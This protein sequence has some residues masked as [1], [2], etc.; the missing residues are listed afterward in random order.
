MKVLF[1]A[2]SNN[3]FVA[4][5]G[6]SQRSNLLLNALTKIADVDVIS[7][8]SSNEQSKDYTIIHQEEWKNP[9]REGRL[10]KFRR[11]L[12]PWNI[13]SVFN[14]D[15]HKKY[16][17]E[18]AL[19]KKNYDYIVIRYIPAA[20]ECGLWKYANK[21]VVDIDDNPVERAKADADAAKSIRNRIY[22]RLLSRAMNIVVNKVI[23]QAKVTFVSNPEDAIGNSAILLPNVPYYTPKYSLD[24][25]KE[26]KGRILF[27]GDLGYWVNQEGLSRFLQN[28]Y[29]KVKN[30]IPYVELHIVGRIWDDAIKAEWE[31]Y[32]GVTVTGFVPDILAEYQEAQV[33]IIPI[34]HGAG[35]CIKVLETMQMKKVCVTTPTGFRGYNMLFESGI[36]SIVA[37]SDDDFASHLIE[38]INNPKL[39]RE[40]ASNAYIK[41]QKYYTIEIFNN[42]LSSSLQ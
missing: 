25:E 28:V 26:V 39:R 8:C 2:V 22:L 9:K 20:L 33:S 29:P 21:L 3:P 18:K 12:T 16:I 30:A 32:E 38:L 14:V 31:K 7:F 19:Q 27:V 10:G 34:C 11:L 17:I 42:T 23:R 24:E 36:D 13:E 40:I 5:Q 41:Q 15:E 6:S 37:N 4:T 1:I 35:T